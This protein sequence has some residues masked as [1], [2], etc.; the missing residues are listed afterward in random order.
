MQIGLYVYITY[1]LPSQHDRIAFFI[2]LYE[3]IW[4]LYMYVSNIL[5]MPFLFLMKLLRVMWHLDCNSC[6]KWMID[7]VHRERQWATSFR[8]MENYSTYIYI[9][10]ANPVVIIF[11][12][13]PNK[14]TWQ[15]NKLERNSWTKLLT[16]DSNAWNWF[17]VVKYRTTN[18]HCFRWWLGPE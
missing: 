7:I 9:S 18:Q 14:G 12:S 17:T 11:L 1:A 10:S 16:L 13:Y 8:N 3:L 2:R 15:W 5:S 4:L 6:K